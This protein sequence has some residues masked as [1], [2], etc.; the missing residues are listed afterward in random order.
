MSQAKVNKDRRILRRSSSSA[1]AQLSVR[2]EMV[3]DTVR[4]GSL[5]NLLKLN[6]CA[7]LGPLLAEDPAIAAFFDPDSEV[8][9]VD[10]DWYRLALKLAPLNAHGVGLSVVRQGTILSFSRENLI[11]TMAQV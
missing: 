3:E 8:E 7:I 6:V 5:R 9:V 10:L 4:N 11:G 2:R 1:S